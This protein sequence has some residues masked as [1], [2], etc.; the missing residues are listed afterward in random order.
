MPRY[1]LERACAEACRL[2]PH[3]A[4]TGAAPEDMESEQLFTR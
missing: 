3:A 4:D 1:I 2:L